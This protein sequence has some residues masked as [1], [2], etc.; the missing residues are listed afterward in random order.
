MLART[1]IRMGKD[2]TAAAIYNGRLRAEPMEPE[3]YYLM[4][5]SYTRQGDDELALKAWSKGVDETPDHPEMLLSL[6]NLHGPQAT[7]R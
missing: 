6:A 5:L 1:S 7:L 4:G 3:D 2:S